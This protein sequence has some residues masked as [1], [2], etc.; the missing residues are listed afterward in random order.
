[1]DVVVLAPLSVSDDV[2]RVIV[3]HLDRGDQCFFLTVFIEVCIQVGCVWVEGELSF[4]RNDYRFFGGATEESIFSYQMNTVQDRSRTM[5]LPLRYTVGGVS[6]PIF[7]SV[8]SEDSVHGLPVLVQR[9]EM[10]IN[11]DTNIVIVYLVRLVLGRDLKMDGVSV[12]GDF[13]NHR[14]LVVTDHARE[15]MVG[16]DNPVMGANGETLVLQ[17]VG[18]FM[19]LDGFAHGHSLVSFFVS[20]IAAARNG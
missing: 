3:I 19:S 4:D 11:Y 9:G 20:C 18:D 7:R 14:P 8:E 17:R 5:K 13:C 15:D 12:N 6:T 10:L 2:K 1:M 16:Q